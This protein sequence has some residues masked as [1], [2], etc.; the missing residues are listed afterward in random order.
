MPDDP[1]QEQDDLSR[2]VPNMPALSEPPKPPKLAPK[3]PPHPAAPKPGAMGDGTYSKSALASTAA[4]AFLTPIIVL[5]M[6]GYWLDNRL[7]HATYWL[8][9]LGLL[10]GMGLGVTAL[11]R[12]LNR[13]SR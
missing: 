11:I 5:C 2:R 7:K 4:T 13:L 6:G 8:A 3:L 9:I 10:L 1:K 12:V